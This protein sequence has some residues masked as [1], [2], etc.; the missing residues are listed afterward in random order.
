MTEVLYRFPRTLPCGDNMMHVDM[1]SAGMIS[2]NDYLLVARVLESWHLSLHYL[3]KRWDLGILL[4]GSV[5][6][7]W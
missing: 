6:G 3:P 7:K 4:G 1:P 5:E 2:S